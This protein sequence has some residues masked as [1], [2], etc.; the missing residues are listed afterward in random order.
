MVP[1]LYKLD[2]FAAV[3]ATKKKLSLTLTPVSPLGTLGKKLEP[4][5]G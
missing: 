5:Q 2:Y 3:S 4:C 1:G